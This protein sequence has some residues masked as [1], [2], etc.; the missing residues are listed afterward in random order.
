MPAHEHATGRTGGAERPEPAHAARGGGWSAADR[1]LGL[2]ST[3]GNAAV[4][5]L[6]RRRLARKESCERRLPP[7]PVVAQQATWTCW[8]AALESWSYVSSEVVATQEDLIKAHAT[9]A[10]GGLDPETGWPPVAQAMQVQYRVFDPGAELDPAFIQAKLAQGHVLAGY[11]FD[12]G[13]AHMNVV[14]GISACNGAEATLSVMDP[15]GGELAQRPI[16]FYRNKAALIIGWPGPQFYI[17]NSPLQPPG[18]QPA[19]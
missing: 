13:A 14:Y 16:S 10:N 8:A 11:R 6:L 5:R 12:S 19:H 2:Q 15:N 1:V 17:P 3:A 4:G 7:P 18:E 9:D